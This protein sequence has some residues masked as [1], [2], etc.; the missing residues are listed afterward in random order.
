MR[1]ESSATPIQ[2]VES[3]FEWRLQMRA[4]DLERDEPCSVERSTRVASIAS[5]S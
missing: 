4:G 3:Q 1:V 2:A 5:S